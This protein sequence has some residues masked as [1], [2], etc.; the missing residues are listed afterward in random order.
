MRTNAGVMKIFNTTGR[1]MRPLIKNNEFVI[2]KKDDIINIGDTIAYKLENKF[3]IHRVFW[4]KNQNVLLKDDTN[5]VK[6]H[7]I[8]KENIIGKILCKPFSRGFVGLLYSIFLN[9]IFLLFR[10]VKK[11]F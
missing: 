5:S 3:F 7:W 1:S 4:I 10:K 2:V 8:K 9:F 6:F 11:L